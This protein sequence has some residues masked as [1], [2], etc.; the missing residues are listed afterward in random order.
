LLVS[1]SSF[2]ETA[3][4][5]TLRGGCR[6]LK[7]RLKSDQMISTPKPEMLNWQC[8]LS[9]KCRPQHTVIDFSEVEV[10]IKFVPWLTGGR[11]H[12]EDPPRLA[13]ICQIKSGNR[14]CRVENC[15]DCDKI[16]MEKS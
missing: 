2:K 4:A 5:G 3:S 8:E 16:F 14:N 7:N 15:R 6:T 13:K 12:V 11:A 10:G 1:T 9:G